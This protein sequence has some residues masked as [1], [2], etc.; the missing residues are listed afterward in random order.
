MVLQLGSGFLVSSLPAS[1]Y[2]EAL[3]S[4][5]ESISADSQQGRGRS[6]QCS[7]PRWRSTP[8]WSWQPWSDLSQTPA[9]VWAASRS[10]GGLRAQISRA[11]GAPA[12]SPS[13][14]GGAGNLAWCRRRLGCTAKEGV[15]LSAP[16]LGFVSL[17]KGN[18][19]MTR[20]QTRTP[21]VSGGS[22]YLGALCI[23]LQPTD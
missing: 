16:A 10:F 22:L 13:P 21:P 19:D 3:C 9:S 1:S 5:S 2:W 12:A 11:S 7:H 23:N 18:R 6:Y 4:F 15:V 20:V 8:L 17:S 14:W